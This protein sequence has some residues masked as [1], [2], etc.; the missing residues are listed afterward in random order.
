[1]DVF[2]SIEWRQGLASRLSGAV[3]A[4][5]A[6]V[7]IGAVPMLASAAISVPPLPRGEAAWPFY[8]GS[9][10]GT[11]YSSL[12]Q[13]NSANVGSLHETGR[14][15]L[16]ETT[17]FQ[18]EPIVAGDALFVTTATSTYA[19]NAATGKLLWEPR[20]TPKSMGLGTGVR[21]PRIST[22]GCIEVHRTG[23]CCRWTRI[24]AI[25]F[26]MWWRS[27]LPRANTSRQRRSPGT[28][29]S[30]SG[31]AAVTSASSGTSEPLM[32]RA[33][34]GMASGPGADSFGPLIT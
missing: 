14:Y 2:D 20:Y 21:G 24:L 8:N 23:I 15:T 30:I 6:C 17:S 4:T 11:R 10:A 26:G 34:P 5:V 32:R 18:S 7:A 27:M 13:I 16:P 31:M 33:V 22:A 1:M 19:V 28:G 25:S 12:S 3:G 9:Y 29:K